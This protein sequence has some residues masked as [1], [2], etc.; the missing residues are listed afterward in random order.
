MNTNAKRS[1][2]NYRTVPTLVRIG[3]PEAVTVYPIGKSKAFDPEKEYKVSFVPAERF[4]HTNAGC[5]HSPDSVTVRPNRDGSISFTYTYECEQEWTVLIT[6]ADGDGKKPLDFHVYSLEDDLYSRNPYRGD[7][8]SH[9]NSSDGRDDP[10]IVAANYRKEGFDFFSLTDHHK[11]EPSRDMIEDYSG[12][13]LGIKLFPGEEIHVPTGWIHIVNFGGE[14]SINT[15]YEKNKEKIDAQMREEAEKL[16]TPPYVNPLEYA[17][18]RWICEQV[19]RAGGL[20]ITAH[21]YWYWK[22]YYSYNMCDKM[23]E[24]VFESGIYDAFELVGGQSVH[25]NNV[26]ISFY[27]EMRANGLKIPIVGSSD[28]HGTDPASYFGIGKTVVFAK[29]KEK[30]SICEAIKNLYSVAIE[31]APGEQERVYGS[32]RLVKYTRFLLD[33]YFPSH[34]ELCVE[35]GRLM[36]EYALGSE[37]AGDA[38]NLLAN[39]TEE[40]MNYLLRK[41]SPLN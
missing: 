18:R 32:Y 14:Y 25:E 29:D 22:T 24:Y 35:E 33:Y 12:V 1:L 21:P 15:L 8:H 41:K 2:S 20:S 38:L 39:R 11:W 7:L 23:L 3:V 9:S 30:D 4:A 37:S 36:R 6:E 34:D 19:R 40:N 16:D 10:L 17:Y 26:Q 13:K 28:S 31:T 27:Q 5:P